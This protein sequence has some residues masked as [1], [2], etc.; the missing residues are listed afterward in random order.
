MG[1][2]DNCEG[3]IPHER[4]ML[5]RNPHVRA[6][7]LAWIFAALGL[8]ASWMAASPRAGIVFFAGSIVGGSFY[9]AREAIEK[10]ARNRIVGIE[11][12]M[13]AAIAGA[14]ALGQ[15]REAALV[16]CLYSISEALEGFTIQRTR[17]AIRGLMDLVPPKARV[18][19][20]GAESEVDV[21]D[22]QVGERIQVRPGENIPVDGVVREGSST[23][24]ESAVTGESM[25]V[26]KSAGDQ[27]FA[28]TVNGNGALVI[29]ATKRFEEN[30]VSKI[31]ELVEQ[32][33]AQKGRT[34]LFVER[35]AKVYSPA[36]LVASAAVAV[37]PLLLGVEA[38]PWLRR[39]VSLL[40]AASPCALAVATPVTLVA[41]IGSAAKRGVL[42]KGGVIL[43]ALGKVRAVALDKTGT[44][45]HGRP[46]VTAIRPEGAKEDEV[47]RWAAAVEHYS[48]HPLASAVVQA[49]KERGI[50]LPSATNFQAI[51]AA[52]VQAT[53][54]GNQVLV[55]KPAAAAERGIVVS[56]DAQVWLKTS[57]EEGKSVLVVGHAGRLLG[58]IAVADTVR[59]EARTLVESLKRAGVEHVVMLTGDN[60]G[61]AKAIAAQ[62]GI[63]EFYGGL[64]PEDKVAKVKELRAKYGGVAMV[65][66]GINDA[67]ALAAASVGIA[68]GTRGSDAAIAAADV[69]LMADD[70]SK[71]RY[72]FELG[73]RSRRVITQNIA[74]SLVI[75][76]ALVVATFAAGL[77]MFGAVLGHEGS[78]VLIIFNGLRVALW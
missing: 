21:K 59:P 62:V 50:T 35:F 42:I 13:T 33:Q 44:V 22:I 8:A 3:E 5:W 54:E 74:A 56:G 4:P 28:G 49:A 75:V 2:A 29:E 20:N 40:V 61:T 70:L 32:A 63:V 47:L 58:L 14:A 19:R 31:I 16:A 27:A 67:P 53:V 72:A 34:Q 51:T 46:V 36:V 38:L 15:W 45:T 24:D 11:F 7:G 55:L 25:P 26:D 12:L 60:Q 17:F 64:L 23:I 73:R 1:C 76:F 77:S 48:E 57:Q 30:T 10:L 41:A 52:G 6:S 43:E 65:G 39:A 71:L 9:F 18:L 69:A 37:V 66:D 68:M 78:E